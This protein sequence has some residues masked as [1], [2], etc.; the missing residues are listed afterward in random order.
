MRVAGARK[1]LFFEPARTT[2]GIVTCGGLCPGLNDV[3]RG[4]VMELTY[5]Y[6]VSTIYGFRYG[7]EG[8]IPRYGHTPMVLKPAS[9]DSIHAFGEHNPRH[10]AGPAERRHEMVDFLDELSVDLLFVVGGDGSLR[11]AN[12]ISIGVRKRGQLK[13][14]SSAS[15]RQSTMTSCTWTR[16]SA[17]RPPLPRPSRP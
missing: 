16:A 6:G 8:L 11:G 7:Y 15:R 14:T 2:A 17:S 1:E 4:L 10:L 12:E 9:M 5:R 3:I 13:S